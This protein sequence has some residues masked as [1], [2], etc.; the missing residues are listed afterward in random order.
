MTVKGTA[1]PDGL[2][3]LLNEKKSANN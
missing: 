1:C 2:G 3:K